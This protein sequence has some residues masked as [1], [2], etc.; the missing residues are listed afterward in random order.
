MADYNP[1]RPY[2]LG[3]EFVP[4]RQEGLDLSNTADTVEYGYTTTL[5]G[6]R[7]LQDARVYMDSPLWTPKLGQTIG[8]NIYPAGAEAL[9]GPIKSMVIP[10]SATGN[11]I[12]ADATA[13]NVIVDA[14]TVTAIGSAAT[15]SATIARALESPVAGSNT[16]TIFPTFITNT[17]PVNAVSVTFDITR[18]MAGLAGKRILGVN[19]L[20]QLISQN[21]QAD[22]QSLQYGGQ[23]FAKMINGTGYTLFGNFMTASKGLQRLKM[24]NFSPYWNTGSGIG[25]QEVM[26]WNV[27]QLLNFSSTGTAATRFVFTMSRGVM[28]L[29]TGSFAQV[30]AYSISYIALEIV[31]CEEQRVAQG[32]VFKN[33]LV[34]SQFGVQTIPLRTP[35][36]VATPVLGAGQYTVTVSAPF[37][38]QNV[39]N[40]Y[41]RQ[42]TEI[43][44]MNALENLYALSSVI[45]KEITKPNPPETSLGQVFTVATSDVVPQISL[46]LAT[47]VVIDE[48]QVYGRQVQAPVFGTVTAAQGIDINTLG[49][50]FNFAQVRFYARRFGATT[51]T[52]TLASGGVNATITPAAFDALPEIVDGWKE[53]TLRLSAPIAMGNTVGILQ[54]TWS[55]AGENIGSRWEILGADAPAVSGAAG[56]ALNL[57]PTAQLL[58]ASTYVAGTGAAADLTWLSPTASGVATADTSTDATLMFSQDPP[59]LTGLACT[60]PSQTLSTALDCNTQPNSI[61][62]TLVYNRITWTA[63]AV[64]GSGFG[65][66]EIQRSDAFDGTWQT[67]MLTTSIAVT[68]FNDYEARIGVQSSYR[69][70]VAN[71]L[72][73][74]GAFA[75]TVTGTITAPG[76]T[77]RHVTSSVLTFTTNEKQAGA[78]N[79][80][81]L[82]SVDGTVEDL[83][84]PEAGRV[85]LQFMYGKDFQSAFHPTERGGEQFNRTLLVQQM[86]VSG[87]LLEQGF[88]GM[89]DLAWAAVS[90]VCVRNEIG[91]RWYS[92]VQVPSGTFSRNRFLANVSV[93]I[94]EISTSPSAVDPAVQQ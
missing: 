94:T 36:G 90:Y 84:F 34:M 6:S 56:N 13:S 54:W 18:Y 20:V 65:Y 62:L 30:Y 43:P 15:P 81:Y 25:V 23:M 67:V 71:S 51:T 8:V 93:Q 60:Q 29:P 83:S 1:D 57:V 74:L 77:G 41:T 19:V 33:Q 2:V 85:A 49:T 70:R 76:V 68:G 46:H 35:A 16:V 69:A 14:D 5:T 45:G 66:V 91:D 63:P 42:A 17:I 47:G 44:P 92:N 72:G 22:A 48:A 58:D 24:V 55:A 87:P 78:S 31:Y 9:S 27:T 88:R 12:S 80:A 50:S 40:V 4:I 64:T 3:N 61:P 21:D 7:T 26:P 79:L 53:V 32:M 37:A 28:T 89:R 82:E 86:A 73:F 11:S 75:A 59:T 52:L 10:V 39:D 38:D